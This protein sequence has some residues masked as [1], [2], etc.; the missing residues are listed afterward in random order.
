MRVAKR[1][2]ILVKLDA[3]QLT[4]KD[5]LVTKWWRF[6]VVSIRRRPGAPFIVA[7]DYRRVDPTHTFVIP[8]PER[9]VV[10]NIRNRG[11]RI[12]FYLFKGATCMQHNQ[13]LFRTT[14][15]YGTVNATLYKCKR[16]RTCK[17]NSI[18]FE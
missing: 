14:E 6:P 5:V 12:V 16:V 15:R 9:F 4:S 18:P 1:N 7:Q 10:Q 11:F 2:I 8:N 13:H 3:S 17:N